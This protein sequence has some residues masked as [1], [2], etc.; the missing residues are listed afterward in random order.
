MFVNACRAYLTRSQEHA[1]HMTLDQILIFVSIKFVLEIVYQPHQ[2]A[3]FDWYKRWFDKKT[4]WY[5]V[6]PDCCYL[7]NKICL[8]YGPFLLVLLM[9]NKTCLLLEPKG[10]MG[11]PPPS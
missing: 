9:L 10:F 4:V 5:T 8:N 3:K 11:T 2:I 6:Q 7:S 1:R